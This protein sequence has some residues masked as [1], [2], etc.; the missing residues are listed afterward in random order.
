MPETVVCVGAVVRKADEIL[1]VRQSSGHPLEGQWTIPWGRL[2]AGESPTAAVL[3]EVF[4]EAA[5][6]AKVEGLIGVQELPEP[7][8]GMLGLLFLC[9]HV[10][11]LPAPDNRET[12]AARFFGASQLDEH[13]ESLEPLSEWALRQVLSGHFRLLESVRSGPFTSGRGYC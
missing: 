2:E 1:L 6:T 13:S 9:A 5:V 10:D 3:R 11:G 12:D 4:E 8:R 7:W